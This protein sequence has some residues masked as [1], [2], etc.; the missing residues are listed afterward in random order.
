MKDCMGV[1]V[2]RN[3]LRNRLDALVSNALAAIVRHNHQFYSELNT[4][5]QWYIVAS[6][7]RDR[8]TI[9][10]MLASVY[11]SLSLIGQSAGM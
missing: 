5:E 2:N 3:L 4:I 1:N 10:N 8:G 9:S 6:A 7:A 11:E